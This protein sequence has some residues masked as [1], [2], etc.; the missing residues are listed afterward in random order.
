MATTTLGVR[1]S[2]ELY[3]IVV[4]EAK[5]QK[6]TPSEY[7]RGAVAV[8]LLFDGNTEILKFA[9]KQMGALLKEKIKEACAVEGLKT[10][11]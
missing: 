5:K 1:M 3:D 8:S 4:K 9:G 7:G 10:T 6:M 2:Q 11:A